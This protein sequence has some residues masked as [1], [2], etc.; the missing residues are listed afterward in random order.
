MYEFSHLPLNKFIYAYQI[1]GQQEEELDREDYDNL[2]Y[3]NRSRNELY[4]TCTANNFPIGKDYLLINP[5][6]GW[7]IIVQEDD[8]G[9]NNLK[10]NRDNIEEVIMEFNAIGKYIDPRSVGHKTK[11]HSP[12]RLQMSCRRYSIFNPTPDANSTQ[13][14][15][16]PLHRT[17]QSDS[18]TLPL[19]ISVDKFPPVAAAD[20]LTSPAER[21]CQCTPSS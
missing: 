1:L 18:P 8:E 20:R 15:V 3:N 11:K 5:C 17:T 10:L 2:A 14:P 9:H 19:L 12:G 21:H 4:V 7:K 16:T 6:T 13:N